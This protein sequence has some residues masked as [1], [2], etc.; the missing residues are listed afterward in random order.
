MTIVGSGNYTYELIENWAKLPDG[1]TFGGVSAVATDSQD[2]VYAFQRKDPPVVIFDKN[3][4]YVGSWGSSAFADPHGINI[5]NDVIYV[6]DRND[7]VALK[8]TL[9]GRPLMVIGERGKASDTGATKDIELPPRSAGPFNKPTE[10]MVAPSGELYVSD[11]YRNSRVHRFSSQGALI[12]SWGKPGK[13]EPGEFHLPHSLWVDRGGQIYVCDRENSRIQV[14][15]GAGKYLSQWKDIHKPTDIVFDKQEIVYVSE[16]RP[17][18]SVLEKNGN[19]LAR[20][21]SPS[22]HGLW[23]DSGGDI[24]LA[25]VSGKS[26]TKYARKR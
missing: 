10:M 24:Y 7:H 17:S 4:T 8:F 15:T 13:T 14:F 22:G 6:T 20:F 3:G 26:L 23:V 25:S 18:I 21:D 16:Q 12:D 19:V 5:V 2:R 9:D 1:W 11:G